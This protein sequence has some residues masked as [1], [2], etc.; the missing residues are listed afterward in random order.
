MGKPCLFGAL[1]GFFTYATYDLTNLATLRD[2]P[3]LVSR[4]R[5]RLGHGALHPG[6]RNQLPDRFLAEVRSQT[7]TSVFLTR[8][9]CS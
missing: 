8:H 2:W 5:Y 3:V 9:S 1:F 4:G 7:M 6:R